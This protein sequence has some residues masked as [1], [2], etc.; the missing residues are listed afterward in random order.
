MLALLS[1]LL[2]FF[3]AFLPDVVKYF[4][5]RQ[6]FAHDE[7]MRR[8]DLEAQKV[9]GQ[10]QLDNT[11]AAGDVQDVIS[12]RQSQPN[13]GA[14][15]LDALTG[16]QGW[17]LRFVKGILIWSLSLVE[18]LN[19]LMRPLV[20]YYVMG[21]WGAVKAARFYLYIHG[22]AGGGTPDWGLIAEAATT[23]WGEDDAAIVEYVVG[24]LFGI[25]HR[26]KTIS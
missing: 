21:L 10:I 12:A 3:S 19:G 11:L 8:I 18:V 23:L 26:L 22:A 14:K 25:R 7:A 16:E 2:G 4:Q 17:V 6:E 15:L 20:V 1:P 13:Y 5:Q 9:A 24:F